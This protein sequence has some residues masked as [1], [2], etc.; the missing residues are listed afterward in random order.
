MSGCAK[1]AFSPVMCAPGD[2]II[3]TGDPAEQLIANL[4][5]SV[6]VCRVH[7][8][9]AA[10]PFVPRLAAPEAIVRRQPLVQGAVNLLNLSTVSYVVRI[11]ARMVAAELEAFKAEISFDQ[12][13]RA[14]DLILAKSLQQKCSPPDPLDR[15]NESFALAHNLI[16]M[17]NYSL[18]GLALHGASD[19]LDTYGKAITI[20]GHAPLVHSMRGQIA[21][22]L[23][24]LRYRAT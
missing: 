24:E 2:V 23:E 14:A 13:C 22:M 9:A 21:T 6:V 3:P 5:L 7:S 8:E 16:G 4:I 20:L 10:Q 18:A 17:K 19:A 1:T 12:L 11:R 15:A